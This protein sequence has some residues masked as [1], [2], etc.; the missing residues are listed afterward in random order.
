MLKTS[1]SN[2]ACIIAFVYDFDGTLIPGNMQEQHL[3]PDLGF[4]KPTQF[5]EQ[6]TQRGKK[7]N[8]EQTLC[9]M[10]LLMEHSKKANKPL[11]RAGLNQY[12]K[13]LKHYFPGVI[14]LNNWFERINKF[15]Q[16][17]SDPYPCIVEHYFISAGHLEMIETTP[18][19]QY[20][21]TI[22]ASQFAYD[23]DT[24]QAFWPAR[25]VNYTIKTQYL[26]RISKGATNLISD[27][28]EREL[29]RKFSE[30]EYRIP[31]K[32]FVYIGDGASD[33]PSFSLISKYQ[34]HSIAVYSDK[35]NKGNQ[36][37]QKALEGR[38]S[39][40]LKADY[41]QGKPIERYCKT[42]ISA[43]YYQFVSEKIQF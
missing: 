29:N 17:F 31:F 4:S 14:G 41:S 19:K 13:K 1:S 37:L 42:I 27:E 6:V 24:L 26:Y 11:T 38:V 28:D 32:R 20:A 36:A 7:L 30:K 43:I 39:K 33:I 5:W 18:I 34:G 25:E 15:A 12:G 9:Y 35:S 8:M 2:T 22:F 40:Y 16:T 10:Y 21:K 23:Q 3:L